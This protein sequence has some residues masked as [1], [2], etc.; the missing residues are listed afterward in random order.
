VV[1]DGDA[2]VAE[3]EQILHQRC[4]GVGGFGADQVAKVR[5][6]GGGVDQR[7]DPGVDG[8]LA[9]QWGHLAHHLA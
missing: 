4:V 6:G 3:L 2:D 1:V 5:V 7:G 8:L 9:G